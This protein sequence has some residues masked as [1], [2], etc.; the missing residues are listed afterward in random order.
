MSA[1]THTINTYTHTYISNALQTSYRVVQS[2]FRTTVATVSESTRVNGVENLITI[3]FHPTIALPPRA[4]IT[5]SGFESMPTVP[6]AHCISGPGAKV[7]ACNGCVDGT[8]AFGVFTPDGKDFVL[9][10]RNDSRIENN[11]PTVREFI[12]S[13]LCMCVLSIFVNVVLPE[14]VYM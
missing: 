5:I 1:Y 4:T 3:S 14:R 9:T 13:G 6:G 12:T 2:P 10:V 11:A 7:F 8:T